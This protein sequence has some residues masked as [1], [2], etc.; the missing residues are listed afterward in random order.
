MLTCGDHEFWQKARELAGLVNEWIDRLF[1]RFIHQAPLRF[2]GAVQARGLFADGRLVCSPAYSTS[3]RRE[4][5]THGSA[6]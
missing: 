3:A 6:G 1:A 5:V 4:A 2:R